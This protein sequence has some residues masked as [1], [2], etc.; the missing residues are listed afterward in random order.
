[1]GC[2]LCWLEEEK[3][4]S[5]A[6]WILFFM[7]LEKLMLYKGLFFLL[8]NKKEKNSHLKMKK[9]GLWLTEAN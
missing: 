6:I 2:S 9:K 8:R 3:K 1:M 4:V 5:D 7:I